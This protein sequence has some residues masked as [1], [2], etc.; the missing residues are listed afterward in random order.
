MTDLTWEQLS[1]FTDKELGMC[2]C[3]KEC[4]CG[5]SSEGEGE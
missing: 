5:K 1:L 3:G 4:G 2:K